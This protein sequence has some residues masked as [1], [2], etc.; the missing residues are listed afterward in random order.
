MA[1]TPTTLADLPSATTAPAGVVIPR[2]ARRRRAKYARRQFL[3]FV[4]ASAIGTGLAFAGLFPTA[5]PAGAGHART[6]SE[7]CYGPNRTSQSLTGSTGCCSCGSSVS[8]S[9]CA[10]S[11]W[12]R[13]DTVTSG[14][15][16]FK[17]RLRETSCRGRRADGTLAPAGRNAWKWSCANNSSCTG[18]WRCSDGQKMSCTITSCSSWTNTVCP[19]RV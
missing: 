16:N 10:S 4:G 15:T 8:S 18:T 13:H 19:R 5:R 2:A 1:A 12:H 11:G 17:W 3:G 9:H 14:S 6:L 7:G